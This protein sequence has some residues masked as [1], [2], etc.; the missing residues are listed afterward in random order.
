MWKGGH[1]TMNTEI[2]ALAMK[3]ANG[4]EESEE[5]LS[6]ALARA[7]VQGRGDSAG[8]YYEV[9]YLAPHNGGWVTLGGQWPKRYKTREGAMK[10]ARNYSDWPCKV[11]LIEKVVIDTVWESGVKGG[12]Q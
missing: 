4:V 7:G 6:R 11:V 12:D 2:Q 10:Q 1:R 9:W 3:V 5:P 8:R